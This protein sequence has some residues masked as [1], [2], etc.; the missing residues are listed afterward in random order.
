MTF[1][2]RAGSR[3]GYMREMRDVSGEATRRAA[4]PRERSRVFAIRISHLASR[5]YNPN[6]SLLAG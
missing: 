3:L 6:E 2:L 5:A 4:K 1:S